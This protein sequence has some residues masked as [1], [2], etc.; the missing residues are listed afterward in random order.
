MD[1]AG[2]AELARDMVVCQFGRGE[3]EGT[4]NDSLKLDTSHTKMDIDED[5]EN[6]ETLS[7]GSPF[8]PLSKTEIRWAHQRQLKTLISQTNKLEKRK[9]GVE[10]KHD[11]IAITMDADELEVKMEPVQVS[12]AE[13]EVLTLHKL[14]RKRKLEALGSQQKRRRYY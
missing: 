12:A 8:K 13:K 11:G 7:P 4:T 14:E 10:D 1:V 2:K 6:T 3:K 5:K 9:R